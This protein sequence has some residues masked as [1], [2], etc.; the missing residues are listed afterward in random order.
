MKY[1]SV[2][3]LGCG[4]LGLPMAEFFVSKNKRVKGSTTTV[5]KRDLLTEKNIKHYAIDLSKDTSVD[6]FFDSELLIISIPPRIRKRNV[7]EH[8]EEL[9][10]IIPAIQASKK[11]KQIVYTSSTSIYSQNLE[12]LEEHLADLS[13]DIGQIE[14][15]LKNKINSAPV[16]IIRCAGLMGYDR[17]PC[18]YFAGKNS[19]PD[20][21]NPVNYIHRD[22][23][24]LIFE[25]LLNTQKGDFVFNAVAPIHAKKKEVVDKCTAQTGMEATNFSSENGPFKTISPAKLIKSGYQFKYPNPAEFP[26]Q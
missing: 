16:G 14:E 4:W 9:S 25:H 15:F 13:T 22:D 20:G 23:V 10:T 26:Y 7:N 19:V 11:L 1:N 6:D 21:Q 24:L 2:S 18:K 5:E 8:L 17:M 3:V 12:N